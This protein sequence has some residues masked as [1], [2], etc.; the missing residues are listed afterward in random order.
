M[1]LTLGILTT[2]DTNISLYIYIYIYIF[3]YI[4]IYIYIYI[5]IYLYIYG[6]G[7]RVVKH[8]AAGV[9]GPWFNFQVAQAYL[10]F[11]S[12]A[13]TLAGKQC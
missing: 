10:R 7:G 5:N 1:F 11:N 3:I 2:E 13:S 8:S 4:Y 6:L 12:W 9:K